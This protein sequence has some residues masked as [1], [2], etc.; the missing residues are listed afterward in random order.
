MDNSQA[1]VLTY[2]TIDSDHGNLDGMKDQPETISISEFKATCLARLERVRR[3]GRR[4]L[5]T[6]RGAPVAE[7][8]PPSVEP[9]SG[10]WLGSAAGTG[11]ITGDVVAPV[12]AS[13][14]WEA[15]Q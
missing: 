6:K 10:G 7:I 11:R 15:A 2:L 12:V 1:M 14:E 13:D 9:R 4:L 3:T 5:V 8:V